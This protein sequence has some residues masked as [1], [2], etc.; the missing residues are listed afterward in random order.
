MSIFN[1]ESMLEKRHGPETA[2]KMRKKVVYTFSDASSALREKYQATNNMLGEGAFGQ[3]FLFTKKEDPTQKFAVKIMLKSNLRE[4]QLQLI[5]DEMAV[6]A[7]L[8]HP[9]IVKH[10]ESYE[11]NRYMYIVMEYVEDAIDLW[12]LVRNRAA[13]S[14]SR[15]EPLIPEDEV[16]RLMFMLLQG[17]HHIHGNGVIHRDL[18]PEN[19]LLDKDL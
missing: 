17:I 16:R 9:N 6:L 12:K 2:L 18:K 3:V 14:Q 1:T 11:D 19:C 10:I 5:R 13:E 7:L 8:D 4:S 15:D